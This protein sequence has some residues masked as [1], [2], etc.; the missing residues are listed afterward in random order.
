MVSSSTTRLCWTAWKRVGRLSQENAP[1]NSQSIVR[2]RGALDS[3]QSVFNHASTDT[4]EE[5]PVWRSK[6]N[7]QD[8]LLLLVPCQQNQ[9][10]VKSQSGWTTSQV[11]SLYFT[12]TIS[13][14]VY[15]ILLQ[16]RK[17]RQIVKD[18]FLLVNPCQQNRIQV[19]SQS[20][21]TTS[22]ALS[23]QYFKV[24]V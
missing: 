17:Q 18:G 6:T 15:G 21:W 4:A 1:S 12:R 2:K 11:L 9:M 7:C 23:L 14:S 10:H 24:L 20:E 13:A 22:Q 5:L 3:K 8:W 16:K 19:K